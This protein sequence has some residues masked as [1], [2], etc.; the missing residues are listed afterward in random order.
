MR[1]LQLEPPRQRQPNRLV[2]WTQTIPNLIFRASEPTCVLTQTKGEILSSEASQYGISFHRLSN[3][4]NV[5][6][7]S[8]VRSNIYNNATSVA[9]ATTSSNK[10]QEK[11]SSRFLGSLYERSRETTETKRRQLIIR[12]V[13][14][15]DQVE[16]IVDWNK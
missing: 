8:S 9:L 14:N 2:E 10:A 12:V 7:D 1:L 5:D 6:E 3:K 11:R 13:Y 16:A 4:Q 15:I